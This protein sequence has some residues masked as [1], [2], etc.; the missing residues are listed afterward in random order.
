M[1]VIR[2]HRLMG[3]NGRHSPNRAPLRAVLSELGMEGLC[4]GDWMD[5]AIAMGP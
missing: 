2:Y 1:D 3:D 4:S 5:V